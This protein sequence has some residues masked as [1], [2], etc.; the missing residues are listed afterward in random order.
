M[1]LRALLIPLLAAACAWP[2]APAIPDTPAGH[3][4]QAWLEALN[5]GDRARIEAFIAKYKPPMQLER[6]MTFR[7]QTGGFELLGIDK[8]EPRHI[9][10]RVKEKQRPTIAFGRLDVKD[11][12]PPRSLPS[13]F[14]LCR[15]ARRRPT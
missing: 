12:Y 5:S 1:S 11:G 15:R 6:T 14:A 4:L 3:T 8:S 10:F 9:E 13:V 2:Q 7:N